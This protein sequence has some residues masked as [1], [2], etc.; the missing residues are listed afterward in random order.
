VIFIH[1]TP[2][3]ADGWSD[4]LLN[5]PDGFDYVAVDRPGFG[6]SGPRGSV[7]SLGDQAAALAPLLVSR[8]GRLPILVGHSLGGPIAAQ[9]AAD[10]PGKVGALVIV[11]GSLDP[12]LEQIHWAQPLGEWVGLRA[13]LPRA[14]RN[15]NQELLALKP[16]LE[17]LAPRLVT[18]NCPVVIVHGTADRLVPYAN[19]AF[20]QKM[21]TSIRPRVITL[22]KRDHFL[23]WKEADEVRNAI[24]LAA[25]S[26]AGRC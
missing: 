6:A 4:Y 22:E 1:G 3:S 21:M 9:I 19:V 24:A 15:A 25:E 20:M 13:L 7:P 5:V 17:A 26:A 14:M 23:P 2:G 11:A 12:E 18:L 16:H 8:R 10:Y